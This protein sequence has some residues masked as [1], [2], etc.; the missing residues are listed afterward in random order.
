[1]ISIH[2][3]CEGARLTY[4]TNNIKNLEGCNVVEGSVILS[5][6]YHH[7]TNISYP[8]LVEIT[9]YLMIYSLEGIKSVGDL[10]PN[11]TR[12]HGQEL[13]QKYSLII[14]GNTDLES[15]GLTHLK[16]ISRGSIRIERNEMLCFVN[17]ID[18]S[19]IVQEDFLVD[20]FIAVSYAHLI[21]S[22]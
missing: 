20:N 3:V 16:S 1:M 2:V 15:I 19:M 6:G 9:G 8:D 12:I 22:A 17:T 5:V 11:L 13:F 21:G 7:S 18:W 4:S 14:V 10:F